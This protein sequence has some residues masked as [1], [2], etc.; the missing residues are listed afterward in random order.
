MTSASDE[1]RIAPQVLAALELP[2]SDG[3]RVEELDAMVRDTRIVCAC[4]HPHL[5]EPVS[6]SWGALVG[7]HGR[8]IRRA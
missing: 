4:G 1:I 8:F 5:P 7:D 2:S 3:I 6:W